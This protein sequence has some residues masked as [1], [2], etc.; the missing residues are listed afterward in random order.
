MK[1]N[2]SIYYAITLS[3][4]IVYSG[5]CHSPIPW[6]S[7]RVRG[8]LKCIPESLLHLEN[9]NNKPSNWTL[10]EDWLKAVESCDP[11]AEVAWQQWIYIT[12]R[13]PAAT[14]SQVTFCAGYSWSTYMVRRRRASSSL[15]WWT[16]LDLI[17]Q[18]NSRWNVGRRWFWKGN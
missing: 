13:L 12:T 7:N 10:D 9:H 14:K 1:F 8:K 18:R 11:I 16:G 2:Y 17:W 6:E 3:G 5:R 15:T 4:N